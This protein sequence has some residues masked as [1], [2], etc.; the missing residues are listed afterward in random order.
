MGALA[1]EITIGELAERSGVATSAL[2][3]WEEKGLIASRRTT[4]NQ[5]RYQRA[6]LRR[7]A[8]IRAGQQVGLSLDEIAAA[9]ASLPDGRTP[10]RRDWQRMSRAWRGALDERIDALVQL[11]DTLD[12]CIG[13]G[14][15]SLDTCGLFN[16]GDVMADR[17]PGPRILLGDEPAPS[18]GGADAD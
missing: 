6:T 1:D 14:C 10:N 16:P 13:C 7:V 8:V 4:G 3:F 5:R 15:L 12:G 11:R 18:D 2:R 9:L 17:G